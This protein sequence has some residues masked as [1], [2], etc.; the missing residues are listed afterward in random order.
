[1]KTLNWSSLD[2][3]G[4]REALAR[5]AQRS[6][7]GLKAAVRAIV[8]DVRARG[9]EGLCEQALRLDGEAPRLVPVA[10]P[11]AEARAMLGP[12]QREAI[13][14]AA[15]NIAAFHAGAVPAGHAVETMPGLLVRKVWRPIDRVGLYVPGGKTPLFSTLLMLALPARAA[16]VGEIV[17][18]TPP[19]PQGGLDPLVAFAAELCGIEAVWAVGGAQAI[20]ALGFGAGDIPRVD[21]ICG[22]GNAWVAEAKTLLASIPGGP[23]IDMPAGPS[24]LLVIAD[25]AADP[26]VVAADLLSQA[27]HD[28]SAQV[29]LVT[30]SPALARQV[31]AELERQLSSLP[32]AEVAR[33]SLDNA[34]IILCDDLE[35]AVALA[36]L[37]APE[38]LS[39][40]VEDPEPL[41]GQVRNAGAVFAG[42]LAAETFGDYLAGSSHV[43]PTDGA[44]RAWGGVAVHTFLKA[45]GVQSVSPGAARRAAGPAAALARLEGLEAHARAA[46]MRVSAAASSSPRDE[47]PADGKSL[48]ARLAR[49]EI[50]ALQPMDIAAQANEAFGADAIKLDANENPYPPLADGPL[51]AGLNRY[52]EPQPARLKNAL[53]SLYGV[54][55]SNLVATRG[56]DDAIE[57]LVRT[58]CRGPQDA[59]S[60]CPPTFSAYAHFARLQGARVIE[61][62][63]NQ[64]FDFEADAFVEAVRGE[65]A[66]KLAFICSPNNPTG[67]PVDPAA[68]LRVADALPGTIVVVDEAYLEFSDTPS[69]AAEAAGRP[70]LVVL[71]TLSKAFG[72]AGARIGCAIGT[73]EL[74]G[75]AARALPPYPLP[76][77][78]I[79]AAMSALAPSRRMIHAERIERIKAERERL[80][81]LLAASPLVRRV[82]SGGGNF[83]FLEVDD[84]P[85]LAARL[86]S[87]GIRAR[88]RPK[89]APGGVRLTI[90]T[91]G[92]NEAA[93]AAFGVAPERKPARRGEIIRDTKETK[94]AVAVDL[95]RA[96]PRR[97][98]TGIPFYDHMLDQV[99]AHAGFSLL[100]SCE[101]DLDI[102]GHHSIE[103]CAIALG[104]A[105][106]RALGERRGIGRFGFALPMDETEAQVLIDLSGRPY[107]VFEGSFEAS[108]IGAYPTEMTRH[109]FRSLADALGAAIHVKVS[110]E[111]DHHKTEACFKAFGRALRP[112][113]ARQGAADAV[114]S[115]KGVL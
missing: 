52:P 38:H 73:E 27:E 92:E 3:R 86:A 78:S 41:I 77:L 4:R 107:S 44:A 18:V 11:A 91:E 1:V 93:L 109:V 81:P 89:A 8:E 71:K 48:A 72:L 43:L 34:R 22:P 33:A 95:D 13:E 98:Q 110:G 16:G 100:L 101:G 14:L 88:F 108:H 74:I 32:R 99:A 87:L 58:F 26:A 75:L 111:N 106:S 9:W 19:C 105:L 66:L 76:T 85:A 7:P 83:L 82:R 54:S 17:V 46:D 42:R 115:T 51:A 30:P 59:I 50:L 45:I 62:P 67:N 55:P 37:Y 5:P 113:V 112:A 6:D 24:E 25:E 47:G 79:E 10:G 56:A 49:P 29:L 104:T 31:E 84:A 28:A 36:N 40:A 53:A 70:N 2:G 23:A 61:A 21:K 103:D 102:D 12:E 35:S 63:L 94:I 80:A 64:E 57:I 114:P 68:V 39:L 65:P 60:I 97:V 69:L 15:R 20:A 96:S 90:G